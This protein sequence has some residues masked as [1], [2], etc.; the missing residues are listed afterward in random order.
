MLMAVSLV[1]EAGGRRLRHIRPC[2][3]RVGFAPR[4]PLRRSVLSDDRISVLAPCLR[5]R[6]PLRFAR[7]RGGARAARML[8]LCAAQERQLTGGPLFKCTCRRQENRLARQAFPRAGKKQLPVA[9][10]RC[11]VVNP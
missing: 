7:S 4:R 6:R 3:H 5:S 2:E 10:K 8:G 1:R 11:R 9:K